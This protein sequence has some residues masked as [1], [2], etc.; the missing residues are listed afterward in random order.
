MLEIALRA[1]QFRA[2]AAVCFARSKGLHDPTYQRIFYEL[3]I[4]WLAMAAEVDFE[5][6]LAVTTSEVKSFAPAT[7]SDTET[8]S[9]LAVRP[10]M[11]VC[12]SFSF[13][14]NS[15]GDNLD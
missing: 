1:E 10:P 6:R 14:P 7:R 13:L 4:E 8:H 9:A 12:S 5:K 3:A 2:K 11:N 15:K